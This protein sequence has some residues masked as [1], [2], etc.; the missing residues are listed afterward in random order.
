[1]V[2]W[3]PSSTAPH[4]RERASARRHPSRSR[5]S[6]AAHAPTASRDQAK[7]DATAS[8]TAPAALD[9]QERA[10]SG[11]AARSPRVQNSA[12]ADVTPN[13]SAPGEVAISSPVR[14][15]L[16]SGSSARPSP[17]ARGTLSV[18]APMVSAAKPAGVVAP[19]ALARSRSPGGCPATGT[20]QEGTSSAKRSRKNPAP[21]RSDGSPARY[22]LAA[23]NERAGS[24]TRSQAPVPPRPA[25]SARRSTS[26]PP[27]S[28]AATA[29][30]RS[31]GSSSRG[32][33]ATAAAQHSTLTASSG[34]AAGSR[35][36]SD[37]GDGA[38]STT[39]ANRRR[40]IPPATTAKPTTAATQGS[41]CR[42]RLD[43]EYMT[44]TAVMHRGRRVSSSRD[45]EATRSRGGGCAGARGLRLARRFRAPA[46]RRA[47]VLAAAVGAAGRASGDG[48]H[49]AGRRG[50]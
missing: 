45:R 21:Y 43:R 37:G 3:N 27:V 11:Q 42:S 1:M 48:R 26:V 23:S 39:P 49:Q 44:R 33:T 17:Y 5:V 29:A 41:A 4:S 10:A 38:P 32:A 30:G 22:S 13:M 46:P 12:S 14:R 20:G 36:P 25:A 28:A 2:A 9:R 31:R 35:L 40:K 19:S 8:S 24:K 15:A 47:R 6:S 7:N 34:S 16:R 18:P 50:R